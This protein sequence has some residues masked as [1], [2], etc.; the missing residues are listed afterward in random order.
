MKIRN[1]LRARF[2]CAFGLFGAVL[3]SVFA[4]IVYVSLDMIDDHLID[5]RLSQE[6]VQLMTHFRET[7]DRPLLE[8]PHI[9]SFIGTDAMPDTFRQV[10]GVLPEGFHERYINNEEYHVAVR[11]VPELVEPVYVLYAVATLEF[12][13]KRKFVI[14]AVL[15]AVVLLVIALGLWLG[16]MMARRVIAPV[17]HL[18]E[19]VRGVSPEGFPTDLPED[20]YDD[21]VGVLAVALTESM[22]RVNAFVEREKHFVRDASHELRT[23]VTVIRGA[24]EILENNPAA[25]DASI[26]R[27]LARIHRAVSDMENDIESL[28]W[29]ARQEALN[30][31][32]EHCRPAT[33]IRETIEQHRQLFREKPIVV[34][35][36]AEADP[37]IQASPT[38]FRIILTNLI[39]N[40]FRYTVEGTIAVRICAG[41]V[42]ISDTGVGIDG[43][44][45]SSITDPHT[46]GC[47]SC[48]FG[49]GLAIVKRLCAR[50]GWHFTIDSALGEGTTVRLFFAS[51]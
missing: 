24:V 7:P 2:I 42:T 25:S 34:K 21:E 15:S 29:L 38:I 17:A 26:Q 39:Q 28:L 10:L 40:A 16:L 8:R 22:K 4:V 23:P 49:L 6:V 43:C 51:A 37:E 33:I 44:E 47:A 48:G 41:S 3:G 30:D 46:R 45:L 36:I 31:T 19:R 14:A 9:Q 50:L 20:L 13:E 32:T 27:P 18:A 12:M 11:V 5:D 35:Y 1:S